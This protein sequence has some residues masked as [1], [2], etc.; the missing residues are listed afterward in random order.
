MSVASARSVFLPVA[1]LLVAEYAAR[2]ARR[3]R[4]SRR[5]RLLPAR[6]CRLPSHLAIC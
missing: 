6:A 4:R 2:A 1:V 5:R 3:Q